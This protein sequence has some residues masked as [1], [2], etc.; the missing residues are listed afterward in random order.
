MQ[1]KLKDYADK[2]TLENYE[3]EIYN[4]R[5]EEDGIIYYADE[6]DADLIAMGTHGRTGLSHFFSGSI[7][8]DVANH[9]YRPV[10][11]IKINR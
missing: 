2:H 1:K 7:A 10:L 5:T 8:E 11:A 9:S 4:D 3:I 6:I